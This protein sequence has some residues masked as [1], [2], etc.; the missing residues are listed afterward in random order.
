MD[1]KMLASK[2]DEEAIAA[3]MSLAKQRNVTQTEQIV[4]G[5]VN[6]AISEFILNRLFIK[7]Y[8]KEER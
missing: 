3:K 6:G 1:S 2:L 7:Q 4:Q 5:L 8:P